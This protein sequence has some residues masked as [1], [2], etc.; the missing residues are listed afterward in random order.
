MGGDNA[1]EIVLAGVDLFFKENQKHD[2]NFNLYGNESDIKKIISKYK[3]INKNN[4]KIIHAPDKVPGNV[5]V[6]GAY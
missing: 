5:S 3:N 2:V 6:R 1:P 4:S